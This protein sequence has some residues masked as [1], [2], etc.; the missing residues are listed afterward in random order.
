MHS[1]PPNLPPMIRTDA[2]NP[3]AHNTLK[4]R[5]PKIIRAIQE[6]NPDFPAGIQD[7]FSRLYDGLV[8]N[9]YIPN[10]ALPAPDADEWR[11]PYAYAAWPIASRPGTAWAADRWQGTAWF[12]AEHYLYRLV[13]EASRWWET[14]RD[15]FAPNKALEYASPA[16][17][18]LLEIALA[19]QS[20]PDERVYNAVSRALWGNRIDL[21]YARSAELG[22]SATDDDLLVDDRD[23]ITRYLMQN[24]RPVHL[25]ADNAGTE[26]TMDLVLLDTLLATTPV[27]QVMLHAKLHPTFVSDATVPDVLGFITSLVHG[28][29]GQDERLLGERLRAALESGRLRLAPDGYWNSARPIWEMPPRLRDLFRAGGLVISKGDA[30]YRRL[31]GDAIWP[32]DTA[33]KAVVASVP[34][35]VLALRTMKSDPIIGMQAERAVALDRTQPDWRVDGQH[36]VVQFSG[37]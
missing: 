14:G 5:K 13:I 18:A 11:L 19:E 29:H 10:L 23:A 20:S 34:A 35:P 4:V 36:G 6:M 8:E 37:G 22:H 33:F 24:T 15:P 31:V 17:W 16:L 25:V 28:E 26:L 27:E 2:S 9:A 1:P 32:V 21:S 3:F 12:F 30:N 7:A